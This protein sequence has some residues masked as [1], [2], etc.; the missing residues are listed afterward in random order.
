MNAET[1]HHT[2]NQRQPLDAHIEFKAG[3]PRCLQSTLKEACRQRRQ[4][5]TARTTTERPPVKGARKSAWASGS[6]PNAC[7]VASLAPSLQQS[8]F[9]PQQR[10]AP[11]TAVLPQKNSWTELE[12]HGGLISQGRWEN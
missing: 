4:E 8:L 12:L 10:C 3:E 2:D 11:K 6:A 5:N 7:A 1:L 9:S